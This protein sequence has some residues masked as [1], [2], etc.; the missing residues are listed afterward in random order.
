MRSV[1][2]GVAEEAETIKN[3]QCKLARQVTSDDGGR[4]GGKRLPP[5]P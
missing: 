5:G 2:G 4:G 1:T 3:L